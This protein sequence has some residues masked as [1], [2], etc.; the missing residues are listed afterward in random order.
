MQ[1]PYKH[2]VKSLNFKYMGEFI[3]IYLLRNNWC[4]PECVLSW[5]ALDTD[6]P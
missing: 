6:Y 1:T 4:T 3:Q 2:M 5:A